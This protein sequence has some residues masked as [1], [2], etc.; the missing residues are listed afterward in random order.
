MSLSKPVTAACLALVLF[1]P[2]LRAASLTTAKTF[3]LSRTGLGGILPWLSIG[4]LNGDGQQ[5]WVF[6]HGTKLA[7]AY[8]HNGAML[9]EKLNPNGREPRDIWHH[10]IPVVWDLDGDGQDE[11]CLFQSKP[12]DATLYLHICDGASGTV[13]HETKLWFTN[14]TSIGIHPQMSI[15]YLRSQQ[16]ADLL[17]TAQDTINHVRAFD[18]AGKELWR[19]SLPTTAGHYMW[20]YDVDGDGF[21]EV[22]LGLY[23]LDSDGTLLWQL[24]GYPERDHVDG[25]CAADID[26]D[27]PGLE[28]AAS[29]H[30]GLGLYEL[31][32]GKRI[33]A[34]PTSGTIADPQNVFVG[35]FDPN[36]RG[37][38]LIVWMERSTPTYT[39]VVSAR[40]AIVKNLGKL[41]PG[42][43]MPSFI[44]D[45]DG[46]RTQDE[47]IYAQGPLREGTG[48]LI[49]GVNWFR[50][51]S[52]D[53]ENWY[54]FPY[55]IDLF[56]DPRE[57]FVTFTWDTFVIGKNPAPFAGNIPSYRNLRGYKLRYAVVYRNP[58]YF[59]YRQTPSDPVPAPPSGLTASALSPSRIRLTWQDN[60]SN[61][62][63]FKIDRRRSGTDEWVRI[64]EPGSNSTAHTDSGLPAATHFY[65]KIRAANSAGNSA[66]SAVA[67][68]TTLEPPADGPFAAYNDLCWANGQ[69]ARNITTFTT[70]HDNPGGQNEGYLTDFGTGRRL[71]A[72]VT[73]QGGGGPR[74]DQ[75]RHPAA[76]T[77]AHGV[78]D[79]R[80]DCTGTVTYDTEDLVLT[81][82][83]LSQ[84]LSYEFVLYSDRNNHAYQ[85]DA[86]RQ[87]VATLGDAAGFVNASTPGSTILAR[88]APADTTRY[89][90]GYNNPTGF[91]TRFRKLD[92]GSDGR[93]VVTLA[94]DADRG[95]YTY[96]NAFALLGYV[97]PAGSNVVAVAEG[98]AWRYRKGTRECSDPPAAWREREFDDSGW[99]TGRLP[100]GYGD[101]P[102]QT[103]LG[104]M[105]GS[106]VSVFL[107]KPFVIE[108]PTLVSQAAIRALYDD[109]FIAWLNG[110]EIGRT[111]VAGGPGVAVPYDAA[112]PE[113]IDPREWSAVLEGRALPPL[114]A[115]T[116]ILAV[117]AFNR[118][119]SSSDLTLDLEL[120]VVQG[121]RV[122]NDGDAD[123]M[124]DAWEEAQ[125]GGTNAANGATEQ[126]LDNDGLKNVEEFI[127]GTDPADRADAFRAELER[128]GGRIVVSLPGVPAAGPGYEGLSRFYALERRAALDANGIW[129][130]VPG[131]EAVRAAGQPVAYTNAA[132]ALTLYRGRVWLRAD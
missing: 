64:A 26:P 90:A 34:L 28:L 96:A 14:S 38:E 102:Y 16:T 29:G 46:N 75:G 125:F 62:T 100:I 83:G 119:L 6:T 55:A 91:V 80:V 7:R 20:P 87:H 30:S 127:A 131:Y 8:D 32:T 77:D 79:G 13:R 109:G 112:A 99:P 4:D 73:V 65:Y 66:Y 67:A 85:G 120:A 78:F 117:Q 21:D 130:P 42:E 9:W 53:R 23:T 114:V 45:F 104:D 10:D 98:A 60:A 132:S 52:F 124:P 54:L 115:G 33:W 39:Y 108:T 3:P 56:G 22:L 121:T 50:T 70:T 82:T 12:G 40:G 58:I 93:L 111:N 27:R 116:N 24:E 118:D 88:A 51:P 44:M 68:A 95:Y 76:G 15:A 31:R 57:E 17:I 19:R 35:E 110:T 71:S 92:P 37:L 5:D 129:E 94:R 36:T 97:V 69:L 1:A 123:G 106:Y 89:N 72:R 11:V 81:F 25:A 74:A 18:A 105:R 63:A 41:D 86:A 43:R 126:D 49:C 61:E 47:V 103:T 122:P 84:A 101:G 59:D 107:R 113:S 48:E 2:A 128:R